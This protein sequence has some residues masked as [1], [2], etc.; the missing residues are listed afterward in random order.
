MGLG[1][2]CGQDPTQVQRD[3]EVRLLRE[4]GC[5]AVEQLGVMGS[6]CPEMVPTMQLLFSQAGLPPAPSPASS[7]RASSQPS[8]SRTSR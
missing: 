7:S 8:T 6:K 5:S 1:E 4:F 3:V 2:V